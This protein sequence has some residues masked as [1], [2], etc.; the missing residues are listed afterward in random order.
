MIEMSSN[1]LRMVIQYHDIFH[2]ILL[3]SINVIMFG[4]NNLSKYLDTHELGIQERWPVY[5]DMG[6]IV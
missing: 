3:T 2:H 1:D 6:C 4:L 5:L